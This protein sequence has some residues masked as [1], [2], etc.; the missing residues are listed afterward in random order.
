MKGEYERHLTLAKNLPVNSDL[1]NKQ[2]PLALPLYYV[3]K[4]C[5]ELGTI[6]IFLGT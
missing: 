5:K 1:Y 2:P 6:A 4:I 3:E